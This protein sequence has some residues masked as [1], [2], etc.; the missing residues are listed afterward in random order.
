VPITHIAESPG[1]NR[2]TPLMNEVLA[3]KQD[4]SRSRLSKRSLPSIHL[5]QF[6]TGLAV[7][8]FGTA[9]QLCHAYLFGHMTYSLSGACR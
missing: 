5:G 2:K 9:L 3:R 7:I 6:E 1:T 4:R 8:D